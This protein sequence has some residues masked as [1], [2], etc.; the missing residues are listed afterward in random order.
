MVKTLVLDGYNVLH[1]WNKTKYLL[2]I[3]L[4]QARERLIEEFANYLGATEKQGLLVFDGHSATEGR[5]SSYSYGRNLKIVFTKKTETA[6]DYIE[7]I[8][9][10]LVAK[11][12]VYVV[13]NDGA[14]QNFV[15]TEGSYRLTVHDWEEMLL[16]VRKDSKKHSE[17]SD[18]LHRNT[19]DIYADQGVWAKLDKLR[20]GEEGD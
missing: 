11:G 4:D 5:G 9:R 6:D 7:K 8:I 20:K 3:D 14:L 13:T 1:H 12:E 10:S 18:T 19:M 2:K 16:A 17:T 15:F